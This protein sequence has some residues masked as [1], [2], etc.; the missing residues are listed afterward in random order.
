M[1]WKPTKKQ[2][3]T[4]KKYVDENG[5]GSSSVLVAIFYEN[6]G[7][8]QC[9]VEPTEIETALEHGAIVF[10]Q[11]KGVIGDVEYKGNILT[12]KGE[13][14]KPNLGGKGRYCFVFTSAP[15]IL[16]DS[17]CAISIWFDKETGE[18]FMLEDQYPPAAG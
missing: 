1:T 17:V 14:F 13:R 6:E 10:G 15:D 9:S 11:L 2:H 8:L 3:L 7:T 4:N 16:D 5:S 12:F 18:C